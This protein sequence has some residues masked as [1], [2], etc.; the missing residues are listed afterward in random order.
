MRWLARISV[1]VLVTA[2]QTAV[3]S[4]GKAK[5]APS[6]EQV[7]ADAAALVHSINLSC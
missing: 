7:L 2:A 4:Y 1:L 3:P 5:A 6:K